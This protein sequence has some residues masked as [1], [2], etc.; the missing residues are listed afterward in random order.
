MA[1]GPQPSRR[2]QKKG[3]WPSGGR[4]IRSYRRPPSPGF[5]AIGVIILLAMSLAAIGAIAARSSSGSDARSPVPLPEPSPTPIEATAAPTSRPEFAEPLPETPASTPRTEVAAEVAVPDPSPVASSA[6]QAPRTAASSTSA[7]PTPVP[8][9]PAAA[10]VSEAAR[11]AAEAGEAYGVRILLDDQDWGPD[12][13]SQMA[14]LQAAI[15]AIDRLPDV[16]I[17]AVVAHAGGPL[18]IVSNDQGRTADGWQPYGGHPMIYYTN[19]DQGPAGYQASNQVVVSVGATS[20]SI[21]HEVLHAYQFRSVGPDEY[22]LALL[23]PEMRSFMDAAGWRQSGSDEQVRQAV[24]QPWSALD[25]L[26]VYEGRPLT[27]TTTGGATGS[28]APANPIEAFA[29]TGSVFYTRPSWMTL[30]DWP[31]YWAWFLENLG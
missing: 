24:S 23:Q 15:S 20:M 28:I 13:A 3:P 5:F 30:P 17:S 22:V 18:T 21:G 8:P 1:R 2:E 4:Q 14:N 7:P 11:L 12:E 25:S 31:E 10:P 26:Y 27:Y 9:V 29:A 6:V 19:S 16:V